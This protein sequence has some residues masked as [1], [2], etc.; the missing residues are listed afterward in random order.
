MA[1]KR[2]QR[3]PETEESSRPSKKQKLNQKADDNDILAN[4]DLDLNIVVGRNKTPINLNFYSQNMNEIELDSHICFQ[5]NPNNYAHNILWRN[6]VVLTKQLY[7]RYQTLIKT[8]NPSYC[9]FHQPSPKQIL[10]MYQIAPSSL[11]NSESCGTILYNIH[12]SIMSTVSEDAH[13]AR[14]RNKLNQELTNLKITHITHIP[15]SEVDTKDQNDDDVNAFLEIPKRKKRKRLSD[16]IE[17]YGFGD[18]VFHQ[19][20]LKHRI[21][22][23]LLIRSYLKCQFGLTPDVAKQICVLLSS[24]PR[25]RN[26]SDLQ[27]SIERIYGVLIPIESL[28]SVHFG[29]MFDCIRGYN[30][31][32]AWKGWNDR[33]INTGHKSLVKMF[34]KCKGKGAHFLEHTLIGKLRGI[35]AKINENI[36]D[37]NE[38]FAILNETQQK[39][40]ILRIKEEKIAHY[41]QNMNSNVE[42]EEAMSDVK[43]L[44]AIGW[45]DP[46]TP[47][48][49]FNKPILINGMFVHW[50]DAKNFMITHQDKV[51]YRRVMAQNSK[52]NKTFGAGAMVC[53]GFVKTH[54]KRK[55]DCM[56]LDASYWVL[57]I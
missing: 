15:S 9:H 43:V 52:Y 24:A 20:A 2:R 22:P 18:N 40:K 35:I 34:K 44:K 10:E 53:L 48:L 25:T 8:E 46:P 33:I 4:L 50:M 27:Q 23:V 29:N 21:T 1:T 54:N 11:Q 31:H 56:F 17:D 14:D 6:K 13:R 7:A 49:L 38:H 42:S 41:K 19:L 28:H 55:N 3:D 45:R 12:K 30:Q 26:L 51:K 32:F 16:I 36:E 39:Q 47:D 5:Q 37:K 57:S